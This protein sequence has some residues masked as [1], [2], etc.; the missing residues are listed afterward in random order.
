M[1]ANTTKVLEKGYEN[2]SPQIISTSLPTGWIP[3]TTVIEGMFLINI[4]PWSVHTNIGNFL[5]RQ[6]TLT[7]GPGQR[8]FIFFLMTLN[9]RYRGTEPKV[10]C[11]KAS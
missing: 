10:F 1:K 8:K 2:A 6:Y 3:D 5:L 9:A 11:E 7:F 4:H